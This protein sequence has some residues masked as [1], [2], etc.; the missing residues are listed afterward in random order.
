MKEMENL[1][2]ASH[3][4]IDELTHPYLVL[5]SQGE[6]MLWNKQCEHLFE[7]SAEETI[8]TI[9]P[10]VEH[11]DFTDDDPVFQRLLTG[12]GIVN[13]GLFSYNSK[14]KNRVLCKTYSHTLIIAGENYLALSFIIPDSSIT[15]TSFEEELAYLRV[16]LE[17][18]FMS[19]SIDNEGLITSANPSFL[20]HSKWTPKRIIGK[21]FWQMFP[22]TESGIKQADKIW[23]SL[24]NN[25]TW[26]GEVEKIA[27]DGKPYWVELSAIPIGRAKQQDAN[28]ILLETDITEKRLLQQ[29]LEK[30]AYIDQETGLM[31]R[32]RLEKIVNEMIEKKHHF[33]FVFLSI[34]KF[35]S[36]KEIF[37]DDSEALL[38]LE[39][40][41]RMKMYFQD[42]VMARISA[43][44]FVVLTPLGEWF[45]QGFLT[46]LKQHPIYLNN[47]STP[48]TISGGITKF[49]EDQNTFSNLFKASNTVIQK[50]QS[51]GGDNI[52]SLSKDGHKE[53]STRSVIEKRLL[54]A[55]NQKDLH[56]LYQPQLD[57]KTNKIKTV[58]ALVRWDDSEIGTV[59]PDILIP[60]AEETG[61]I[62]QIGNFMLEKACL[63][64][65][66]WQNL[67]HSIQVSVNTSIREF[68]DKNMVDVIRKILDKTGCP[69]HLLQIEITE[70]FALEA[71]A[72]GSI[73]K[74]M[75]QLQADGVKF[76]LDDFGTGYASFRYM[77]IL[78]LE[79]F[80]IDKSF[81][82]SVAYQ[83]KTQALIRGMIQFGK[84]LEMRVIA[85]GV[86]TDEQ[87][88][89]L[90]EYDCDAIQGYYISRPI[91]ASEVTQLF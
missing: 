70:K 89:V 25:R 76:S 67:G 57:L 81:I 47:T 11:M 20:K 45:I 27:K 33:T 35:Y 54:I 91:S 17:D 59:T 40:T 31:N 15:E 38:V 19:L 41:N 69:A 32:F 79:E 16:G 50:I 18:S 56:V 37:D 53:L 68:R 85:E 63:Q 28:Y 14:T 52:L 61:L 88:K 84:S 73:V 10:I 4:I 24:K 64:A 7:Y 58:E 87:E 83:N 8:G 29:S 12:Q 71:E 80:K 2:Q 49:P 51:E 6:V 1:F 86:E 75:K 22:Q 72:E 21:T 74:Q 30:I 3:T 34:D 39:F 60:I 43:N 65:V 13:H 9:C 5:N 66:E 62:N 42:S 78:P 48:M 44:E 23:Q 77:Q 46:Y 90:R 26:H 82:S 36:L 55:L